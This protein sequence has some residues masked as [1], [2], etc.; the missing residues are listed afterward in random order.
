MSTQQANAASGNGARELRIAIIGAGP[1][2][3]VRR[4][5]VAPVGVRELNR[6]G[7]ER[8]RGAAPGTTNR[9]PGCACD[10]QSELYSFSFEVNTTWTR[11]YARQPEILSYMERC[12]N[13]YGV[14]PHCRV[15]RRREIGPLG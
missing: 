7:E 3:D 1:G 5:S 14:L 4:H 11:P 2:G 9:Y 10:I 8:R 6:A 12:A 13:K 15:Q